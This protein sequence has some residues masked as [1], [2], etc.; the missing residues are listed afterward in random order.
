MEISPKIKIDTIDNADILACGYK[1]DPHTVTLKDNGKWF[2]LF[3]EDIPVSFLCIRKQRNE[4]YIGEVFTA[5]EY[6]K[7]GYFTTL[8][9]Y[10][11]DVV[12]PEYSSYS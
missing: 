5:Q 6:R 2:A 7:K 11:A 4:L 10:V 1:P 8:L 3:S 12:Y 9:R